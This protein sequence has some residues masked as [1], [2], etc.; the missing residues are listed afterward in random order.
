MNNYDK[1][2]IYFDLIEEDKRIG[3]GGFVK[4]IV[5]NGQLRLT[6]NTSGLH[7]ISKD[8]EILFAKNNGVIN[9]DTVY[10]R[11]GRCVYSRLFSEKELK[12]K[13]IK[14]DEIYAI[15]IPLN[16]NKRLLAVVKASENEFIDDKENRG[17]LHQEMRDDT[18]KE[19]SEEMKNEAHENT[20]KDMGSDIQH[21]V[22][23]EISASENVPTFVYDDKWKQLE[24]TFPQI[25]PFADEREYLS[26]A[27]KDLVVLPNTYQSLAGN[28]FL[29][30]GYYNYHHIIL[31]KII[32]GESAA[33]VGETFYVGVP[34]VFHEREKAVAMMFGFE[35]F[36]CAGDKAETGTFGYYMKRVEI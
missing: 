2:I 6:I 16:N 1:R 35:G 23:E 25:H 19:T 33:K 17:E 34:G 29:L 7:K 26:I 24:V 18:Q 8:T 21:K 3:N 27:P 32:N 13:G 11:E 5:Q 36:E 10:I 20:Q 22:Q 31:G 30:H 28:S 4:L 15:V 9:L 12:D 14:W